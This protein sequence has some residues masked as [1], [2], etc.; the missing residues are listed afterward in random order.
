MR[1]SFRLQHVLLLLRRLLPRLLLSKETYLVK[2]PR[3]KNLFLES[4]WCYCEKVG[5]H[6][7]SVH[8]KIEAV[9]QD[10]NL[11]GYA[12]QC[13]SIRYINCAFATSKRGAADIRN[14]GFGS[15]A[16]LLPDIDVLQHLPIR[17]PSSSHVGNVHAVF[18]D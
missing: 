4:S 12:A 15:N 5:V 11:D 10:G 8:R 17:A 3:K 14:D 9:V 2:F 18:D 16:V 7:H 1:P 13:G 6:D